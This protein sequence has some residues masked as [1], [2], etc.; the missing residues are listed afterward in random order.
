MVVCLVLVVAV[1]EVTFGS[2]IVIGC[3]FGAVVCIVVD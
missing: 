2:V 1:L 3:V